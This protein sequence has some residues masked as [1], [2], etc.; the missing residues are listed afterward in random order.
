MPGDYDGDGKA[1]LAVYQQSTGHWFM[2]W[3]AVGF[4]THLAF[5]GSG[6]VAVPGDYDGDGR[7]DTAVYE[8]AT[9]HWFIAQS[10]AGFRI[11]PSFGG[12]GFVPVLPQVTILRA[13]GLL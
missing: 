8:S 1:D 5:G 9:G 10:T 7:T 2:D 4:E 3:S 6:F 11:H 13:L 12:P